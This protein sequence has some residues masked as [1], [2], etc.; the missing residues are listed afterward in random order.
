MTQERFNSIIENSLLHLYCQ[1]QP[2]C[3]VAQRNR[4]LIRYLRKQADSCDPT[5]KQNIFQL[6]K[7]SRKPNINLELTILQSINTH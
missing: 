5:I 7:I 2:S 4:I 1:I 3:N 6:V